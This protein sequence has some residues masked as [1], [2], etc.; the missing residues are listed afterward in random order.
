ML[1]RETNA[2]SQLPPRSPVNNTYLGTDS[3]KLEFFHRK[4]PGVEKEVFGGGI[5]QQKPVGAALEEK[6]DADLGSAFVAVGA[7]LAEFIR[8]SESLDGVERATERASA[9]VQGACS[10]VVEDAALQAGQVLSA[11]LYF[12]PIRP[13]GHVAC[14]HASKDV[15]HMVHLLVGH[16]FLLSCEIPALKDLIE[17]QRVDRAL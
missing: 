10:A 13:Y 4:I 5:G 3:T 1:S 7:L 16:G 14:K 12:D 15:A 2:K 8:F 6:V 9:S 17:A 11:L